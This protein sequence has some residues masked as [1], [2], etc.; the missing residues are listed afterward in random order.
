MHARTNTPESDKLNQNERVV[1]ENARHAAESLKKTFETWIVIG[2]AVVAA[3]EAATRIG[4]RQTFNHLIEQQGLASVVNKQTATRLRQIMAPENYEAVLRWH[5]T[6]P[7]RNQWEWAAPTTIMKHCPI[8]RKHDIGKPVQPD[9]DKPPTKTQKL[10]DENRAYQSKVAHL[11]E[12]L[13]AVDA[14]SLFD[15][16]RDSARVI[17][18]IIVSTVSSH[19]AEQIIRHARDLL[20]AKVVP[21]G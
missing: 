7:P 11:E 18:E 13:A 4:G 21:A 20:K 19:K 1:F 2:R 10:E 9:A 6:L 17:A 5:S 3:T 16:K 15:L 14:G 8:F 12:Q